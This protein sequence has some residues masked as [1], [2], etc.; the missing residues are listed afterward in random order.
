[1][2]DA[3]ICDEF[4]KVKGGTSK[5]AKRLRKLQPQI[6]IALAADFLP[7]SLSDCFSP[8]EWMAPG[9]FGTFFTHF[10]N[11]YCRYDNP[12]VPQQITGYN[13]EDY[14][15]ATL[16]SHTVRVD[17]NPDD[18][19]PPSTRE[20][21]KIPM[22]P[23][24]REMF[25]QLRQESILQLKTE[26]ITTPNIL[27]K[28]TRLIQLINDPALFGLST[29]SKEETLS[30]ILGSQELAGKVIVFSE[31]TEPIKRLQTR[32]GGVLYIGS[33]TQKQR[34]LALEQFKCQER[35]LWASASGAKGLNIQHAS[36]VIHM[37]LPFTHDMLK[38][39][40][41][42]VHRRGQTQETRE[43][44]LISEGSCDERVWEIIESKKDLSEKF[45]KRDYL[46]M[47]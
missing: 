10:K 26:K 22:R 23:D 42:R 31:H 45:N 8:V 25:E 21:I 14:L 29:G 19:I 41:G 3:I 27:S 36:T 28:L 9:T 32:Y 38:Q 2:P 18:Y 37:G 39:R 11:K 34:T 43:I 20:I 13:D 15:M 30:L 6:R 35:I 12:H 46:S 47:L 1:M 17:Y 16:D 44:V 7:N 5:V 33:M 40:F 4:T 24:E